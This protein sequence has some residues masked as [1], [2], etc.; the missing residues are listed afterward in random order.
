MIIGIDD[1]TTKNE[2]KG[3]GVG[4]YT[5]NMIKWL[6]RVNKDVKVET[7]LSKPFDVFLQPIFYGGFPKGLKCPKVVMIHDLTLLKFNYYSARGPLVNFVKRL[8]Y[9]YKLRRVKEADGVLVNSENSKKD[10]M[11]ML[12]IPSEKVKVAYLGLKDIGQ[13]K[14]AKDVGQP[15]KYLLYV[16]GAEFNK[17]L[18]RLV[19]AFAQ[20]QN[21]KDLK[22][23]LIGK[24]FVKKE[25]KEVED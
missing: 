1:S 22:L 10:V 20:V 15:E 17:N 12:G 21:F 19:E 9:R 7:D 3:H 18:V 6:P 5:T 25:K 2:Y 24:Q 11:E 16:G 23:V 4:V 14:P 13:G 8:L